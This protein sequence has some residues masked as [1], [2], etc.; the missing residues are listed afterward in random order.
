MY[1]KIITFAK[2]F[3]DTIRST[4]LFSTGNVSIII[5]YSIRLFISHYRIVEPQ[6]L[7][8]ILLLCCH[9]VCD[10][11]PRQTHLPCDPPLTDMYVDK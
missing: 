4:I 2:L 11:N 5:K 8:F 1:M 7:P 9:W 6:L 3:L 10:L